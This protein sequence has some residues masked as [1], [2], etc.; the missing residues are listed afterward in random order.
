MDQRAFGTSG[1]KTS[2]LGFG[3]WP[4]GGTVR[5]GDYGTVDLD[6]AVSAIQRAFELGITLFDTAPAYGF[7][8]AEEILARAIGSHRDEIVIATKCGVQWDETNKVWL[9]IS[10]YGEILMSAEA[11]L[12]R[13]DTD[14]LDLLLIHLPD[15]ERSAEESIR[16][17]EHLT[18][19]GKCRYVGVSNFDCAEL[20]A[21]ASEGPIHA[22]QIGYHMFDRRPEQEM[23]SLCDELG[24]GVMAFG[25]LAHGLLTGAWRRETQLGAADWRTKGDSFGQPI[26]APGHLERNID[27]V[28]QLQAFAHER[29]RPVSQLAIAWVLRR[30]EVSVAL[31]GART[32]A[33]IEQNVGGADWLLDEGE[34]SDLDRIIAGAAGTAD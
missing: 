7:G 26:F 20:R 21:F 6:E 25:T 15:T 9:R 4:I 5:P 30:P 3:T 14:R 10:T 1:L 19:S 34:L 18:S 11:S 24:V 23:L 28:D 8:R 16:A 22:Q 31:V 17:F 12:R 13:L 32:R 2:S 29:G 33:E 27:V